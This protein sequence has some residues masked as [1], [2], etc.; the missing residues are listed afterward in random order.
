MKKN[1]SILLVITV[2]IGI[3]LALLSWTNST[4]F[5]VGQVTIQGEKIPSEITVNSTTP[6][7]PDSLNRETNYPNWTCTNGES[8]VLHSLNSPRIKLSQ[9]DGS[10]N[11]F[12][13]YSLV[14]I[15]ID[16]DR[17]SSLQPTITT[18]TK[19]G[20]DT[21]LFVVIS[22]SKDS[23]YASQTITFDITLDTKLDTKIKH[24]IFYLLQDDPK[25]SR[26]TV[27]NVQSLSPDW[28]GVGK[29]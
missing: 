22:Y 20:I 29:L 26:G 1:R 13:V 28:D 25:T 11:I 12:T 8:D 7:T 17:P 19:K 15:P 24:M 18:Y 4:D 3:I 6:F 21:T 23:T 16:P 14:E 2:A 10:E 27:T 5:T 9:K